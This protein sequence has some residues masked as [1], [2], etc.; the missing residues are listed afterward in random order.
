MDIP[1][2][3]EGTFSAREGGQ[4]ILART[5]FARWIRIRAAENFVNLVWVSQLGRL[6]FLALARHRSLDLISIRRAYALRAFARCVVTEEAFISDGCNASR[7]L[8]F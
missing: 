2:I 4:D 6:I 7:T 1:R 8:R 3:V 5:S